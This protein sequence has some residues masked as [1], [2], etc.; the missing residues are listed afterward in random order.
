MFLLNFSTRLNY[1]IELV[2][3]RLF[4]WNFSELIFGK[5]FFSEYFDLDVLMHFTWLPVVFTRHVIHEL[6]V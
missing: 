3:P 1:G 4:L 2:L 6:R 5:Q